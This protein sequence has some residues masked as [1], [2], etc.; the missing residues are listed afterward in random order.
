MV[1]LLAWCSMWWLALG[2]VVGCGATLGDHHDLP[3]PTVPGP[4]TTGPPVPGRPD[5]DPP[6]TAPAGTQ[7]VS[8]RTDGGL[9][10]GDSWGTAISADG[11]V[12]AFT[13]AATNL[14]DDDANGVHDV[15]VHDR[16]TGTTTRVSIAHGGG[17]ADG[18]SGGAQLSGDGRF[19]AFTS[20]AT[21]LVADDTNGVDDVF[22]HD[23]ATGSTVRVS[24]ATGRAQLEHP[25][26]LR[27]FTSDGLTVAFTTSLPSNEPPSH[28]WDEGDTIL[29]IREVLEDVTEV[30]LLPP[31]FSPGRAFSGDG[32]WLAGYADGQV[33]VYDR[34]TGAFEAVSVSTGGVPGDLS[35]EATLSEDGRFVAFESI[36]H[37]L[38][39][40]HMQLPGSAWNVFLRDRTESVTRLVSSRADGLGPA[41]D[42]SFR[43]VV[44]A[45]GRYVV[46]TSLAKDLGPEVDYVG[47]SLFVRDQLDGV[48]VRV[49]VSSGPGPGSPFSYA[50]S[51]DGHHVVFLYGLALVED[52][53]DRPKGVDGL[54]EHPDGFLEVYVHTF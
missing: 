7:R 26:R 35:G 27:H 10:D 25:S 8:L 15:F 32:R 54:D 12:V 50:L 17:D 19:V 4:P 5:P 37:F 20:A 29:Q 43:P 30:V 49:P 42:F 51:G 36:G 31:S 33:A 38:I 53:G 11:R 41:G 13:S 14:V 18:A 40:P 34:T 3:D 16:S 6:P 39:E 52:A 9:P 1:R 2:L 45:S 48:T 24:V 47:W 28:E 23:R 44:D 46:F 22:V 21:N